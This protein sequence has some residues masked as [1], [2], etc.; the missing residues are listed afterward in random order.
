MGQH[1][2]IQR[3]SHFSFAPLRCAYSEHPRVT[4]SGGHNFVRNRR[5]K[6]PRRLRPPFSRP[7]LLPYRHGLSHLRP[8]VS[9]QASSTTSATCYHF[10]HI[11]L[12]FSGRNI[13]SL[14]RI[15]GCVRFFATPTP[16][17][18]PG[19]YQGFNKCLLHVWKM[20]KSYSKA[21][22]WGISFNKEKQ[23]HWEALFS[24][25]EEWSPIIFTLHWFILN[26][27]SG[28]MQG[29]KT[30]SGGTKQSVE[31]SGIWAMYRSN[32]LNLLGSFPFGQNGWLL[33]ALYQE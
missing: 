3:G 23:C 20:N 2:L 16:N 32:V 17:T 22:P 8:T 24:L 31:P 9:L 33:A 15:G 18:T 4:G 21:S 1:S 29:Q 14:F 26:M 5:P 6:N 10:P 19:T 7:S 28:T 30:I 27:L 12:C 11:A 13:Q 25:L